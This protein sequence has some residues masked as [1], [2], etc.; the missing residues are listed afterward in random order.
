MAAERPG[1]PDRVD[2]VDPELVHQQA[3]AGIKG[4]LGELNGADIVLGDGDCRLAV[5]NGVREGPAARPDPR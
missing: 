4:R 3:G 5:A 2:R 1:Q